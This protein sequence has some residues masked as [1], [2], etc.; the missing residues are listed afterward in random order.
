[1]Q[2]SGKVYFGVEGGFSLAARKNA[3]KI[4]GTK[5]HPEYAHLA[6]YTLKLSK[7]LICNTLD[8]QAPKKQIVCKRT[9][10]P[11]KF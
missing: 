7:K 11:T 9:S 3:G 8:I 10:D 2:R 4:F 5:E 6:Q 1:M